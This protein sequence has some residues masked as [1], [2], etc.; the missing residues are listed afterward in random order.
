MPVAGSRMAVVLRNLKVLFTASPTCTYNTPGVGSSCCRAPI[1]FMFESGLTD[2]G[3]ALDASHKNSARSQRS[4][5]DYHEPQ[6]Y[7]IGGARA[8]ARAF[9]IEPWLSSC[10]AVEAPSSLLSRPCLSSLSSLSRLTPCAGA[11]RSVEVCRGL[12]SSCRAVEQCRADE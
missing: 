11:S 7:P 6:I 9:V 4:R 1:I 5:D 10:R 3:A 12:S 8:R 2:R